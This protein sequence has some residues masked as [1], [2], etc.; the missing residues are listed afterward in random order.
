M[1]K[2]TGPLQSAVLPSETCSLGFKGTFGHRAEESITDGGV[3]K[4][5]ELGVKGH[6]DRFWDDNIQYGSELEVRQLLSVAR[7]DAHS[8]AGTRP[9]Q[10]WFHTLTALADVLHVC[11]MNETQTSGGEKRMARCMERTGVHF[12][13]L[14]YP[15]RGWAQTHTFR[16]TQYMQTTTLIHIIQLLRRC[17]SVKYF[18]LG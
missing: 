7:G 1:V 11:L 3:D 13:I 12:W 6:S 8:H 2:N 17:D 5:P 16:S 14:H 10:A 15:I 9:L 18:M 4:T